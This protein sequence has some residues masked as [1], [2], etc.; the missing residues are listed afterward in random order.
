MMWLPAM[1]TYTERISQPAICPAVV[2]AC[3]MDFT[4][5][6]ML[7]TMPLRSP[8]DSLSPIPTILTCPSVSTSPTTAQTFVVPMSS[9]TM[10]AVSVFSIIDS[11]LY[12]PKIPYLA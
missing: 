9:P 5:S 4:V 10:S 8:L 1:P 7:T 2:T 6:S 11:Q 3:W 12:I